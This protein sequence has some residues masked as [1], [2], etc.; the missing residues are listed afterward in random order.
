MIYIYYLI[1]DSAIITFNG[2]AK[3]EQNINFANH[4]L[5]W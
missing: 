2:A 1:T 5:I 3:N 4:Y